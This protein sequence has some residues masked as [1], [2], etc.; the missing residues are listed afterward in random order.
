MNQLM[1]AQ[2]AGGDGPPPFMPMLLVGALFA[3][4]YFTVIYPQNKK[5]REKAREKQE[6]R[7]RLKKGDEVIAAG[8]LYG[9]VV[10]L[11]GTVVSLELAPNVRVRAELRSV[12]PVAPRSAKS[13]DDKE[14]TAS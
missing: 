10:E 7:D 12:E 6:F 11:K 8:G 5:D 3:I 13:A 2:M 14:S 1:L 4:F 9:R